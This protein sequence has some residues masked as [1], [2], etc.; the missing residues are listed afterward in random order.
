[1]PLGGL[2]GLAT[3]RE[4]S[5]NADMV[6]AVAPLADL[7][8]SLTG[9]TPP[10]RIPHRRGIFHGPRSRL[11]V[12][13]SAAPSCGWSEQEQI[14]CRHDR[15]VSSPS[16][17][18][19]SGTVTRPPFILSEVAAILLPADDRRSFVNSTEIAPDSRHTDECGSRVCGLMSRAAPNLSPTQFSGIP[20]ASA[21]GS[22]PSDSVVEADR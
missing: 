3:P 22:E 6:P 15:C 5:R 21:A 10:G 17:R 9:S 2:G 13:L 12:R 4:G 8:L 18:S 1:M 11:V 19:S 7:A 14:H 16:W 20:L